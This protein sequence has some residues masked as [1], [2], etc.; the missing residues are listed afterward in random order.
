MKQFS[1]WDISEL[2]TDAKFWIVV[3]FFKNK[4]QVKI[5][6]SFSSLFRLFTATVLVK[7]NHLGS[8][9][10]KNNFNFGILYWKKNQKNMS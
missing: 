2:Q 4:F 1:Q 8:L 3:F 7:K 5:S 6:L 10:T 9:V